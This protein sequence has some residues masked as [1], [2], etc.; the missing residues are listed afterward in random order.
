MKESWYKIENGAGENEDQREIGDDVQ[1]REIAT[2]KKAVTGK[3]KEKKTEERRKKMKKKEKKEEEEE[4]GRKRR[5]RRR[6]NVRTK[7]KGKEM[8]KQNTMANGKRHGLSEI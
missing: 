6:Q 4:D 8:P 3:K 2:V 7:D 1:C 5:K